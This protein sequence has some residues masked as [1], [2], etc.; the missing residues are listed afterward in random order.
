MQITLPPEAQAIIDREIESGRYTNQTDVIVE[1][2]KHLEADLDAYD[3]MRDPK[4]LEAIAQDDRGESRE[5]TE[6]V[7]NEILERARENL[8]LGKAIPDDVKY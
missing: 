5:L 1:A 4:V 2:L 8:R 3:P 7:M 6:D